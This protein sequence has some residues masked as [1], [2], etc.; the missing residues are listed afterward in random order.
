VKSSWSAEVFVR[1]GD[2]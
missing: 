1:Q 2:Q